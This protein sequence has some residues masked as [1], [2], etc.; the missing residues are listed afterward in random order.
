MRMI[1][2]PAKKMNI[3]NGTLAYQELP[4]FIQEAEIIKT[5]LQGKS[6]GELQTLWKCS[7]GIAKLNITRLKEMDLG[8]NLSPAILSYEGIQYQYMA[9]GVFEEEELAFLQEHLRILSGFYGILRP[10]DGIVPYRLEM[11]AKLSIGDKKHLYAFWNDRLAKQ[12]SMETDFILNLASKEYSKAITPHLAKDTQ[13]FTCTFG[14]E[15]EGKVVEKGTMCKMARG[16][17]VR[18]LVENKITYLDGIKKF[19]RLGYTYSVEHSAENKLIFI[20]GGK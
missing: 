2:S 9:P 10:L 5:C 18:Y 13:V 17:M 3:D 8:K 6:H 14:E 12:L 1:I 4:Q 19:N 20:K 7:D 15:K 16:E 11:Q